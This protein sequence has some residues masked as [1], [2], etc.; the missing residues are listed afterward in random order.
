MDLSKPSKE[1]FKASNKMKGWTYGRK[2]DIWYD[3]L[4]L[5]IL[6]LF[7]LLKFKLNSTAAK[8]TL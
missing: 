7:L 1:S 8:I 6:L 3:S 2:F 5:K 4:K